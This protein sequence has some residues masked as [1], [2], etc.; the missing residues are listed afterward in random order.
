MNQVKSAGFNA[1]F[2]NGNEKK[3]ILKNGAKS[4]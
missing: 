3:I 4:Q 2:V 1:G